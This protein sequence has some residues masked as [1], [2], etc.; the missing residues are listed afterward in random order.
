MQRLVKDLHSLMDTE[1]KGADKSMAEAAFL[2]MDSDHDGVVTRS[3]N[4]YFVLF[5]MFVF[6]DPDLL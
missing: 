1:G 5:D 2:E 3:G 6:L 4:F